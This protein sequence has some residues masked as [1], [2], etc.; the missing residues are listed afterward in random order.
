[1]QK[2]LVAAFAA[3]LLLSGGSGAARAADAAAGEAVF[4]KICVTCHSN[5]AGVNKTGPSLFGVYGR[6]AGSSDFPRY[7]GLVGADF[8]WDAA[9]LDAYLQDP[10][11][12][13]VANTKNSSTAM[14]YSLKDATQRADVIAYLETLK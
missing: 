3:A 1:M 11:A 14:T 10:K 13:V 5:Q 9:K 4:K 7:K 12:F 6:K 8:T 2:P